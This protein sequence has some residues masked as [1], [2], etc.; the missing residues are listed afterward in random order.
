VS[1]LEDMLRRL[2]REELAKARNDEKPAAAVYITAAEYAGRH[3]I[4]LSTVREA[5]SDGRLP[6]MRI[7]R[8]VRVEASA[9]IAPRARPDEDA[10]RAQR[11]TRILSRGAR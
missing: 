2:I 7:G 6:A 5:L 1:E 9:V 3:S 8:A 11:I 10:R 4:S